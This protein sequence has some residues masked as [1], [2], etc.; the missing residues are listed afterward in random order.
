MIR[1]VTLGP[2]ANV[3]RV[4]ADLYRDTR[5]GYTRFKEFLKSGASAVVLG[6]SAIAVAV[7]P[8]TVELLLPLSLLFA[9]WVLTRRVVLPFRLPKFANR[10]DYN[11]PHPKDRRPRMSAGVLNIGRHH[12]TGQ[13][14]WLSNEDARQH[15]A[16]PGTTGA[17]KT[18]ALVS[19]CVN[20]LAWGSGFIFVD[21][22]A[23][24]RL[25]ADVLALARMLWPRGRRAGAQL[26]RGVRQ[27]AVRHL[28]PVRLGQ[29]G[30][31][32]RD[33]GQPDRVQPERRRQG[34]QPRLHGAR[35]GAA[36]CA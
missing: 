29:R 6:A 12:E 13:Q 22:K 28:Q 21:G 35:R 16:V 15:V 10:L 17:G 2:D 32:P 24:N 30:R 5:T 14:L 25:Y 1:R 26:P 11:Y 20:A 4:G 31:D 34:Q 7:E 19:L 18:K 27:Q 23:D 33:P 8:G 36:G 9:T 3:E